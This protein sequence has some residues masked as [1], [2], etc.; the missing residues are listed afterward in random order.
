[1]ADFE[2][3]D[4]GTETGTGNELE[5]TVPPG[6]GDVPDESAEA[7]VNDDAFKDSSVP[8]NAEDYTFDFDGNA[9]DAGIDDTLVSSFK[10]F[11]KKEN[12]TQ[13]LFKKLVSFQVKAAMEYQKQVQ[14]IRASSTKIQGKA[15]TES[16]AAAKSALMKSAAYLDKNHPGHSKAVRQMLTLCGV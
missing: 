14:G 15:D 3:T 9:E 8:D 4:T 2:S 11:A 1:M 12:I 7:E 16:S 13:G 10:V 5:N 6:P